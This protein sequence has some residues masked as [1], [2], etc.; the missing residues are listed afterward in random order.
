MNPLALKY[1][2][3]VQLPEV[4]GSPTL[5]GS[6]NVVNPLKKS[7]YKIQYIGYEGLAQESNIKLSSQI[8]FNGNL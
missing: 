4:K 6:G 8:W 3:E 1:G 2:I 5:D 7:E